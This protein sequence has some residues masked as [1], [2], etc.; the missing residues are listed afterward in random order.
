MKKDFPVDAGLQAAMQW[1]EKIVALYLDEESVTDSEIDLSASSNELNQGDR[2]FAFD[3]DANT[4]VGIATGMAVYGLHPVVHIAEE[5]LF[6]SALQQLGNA[7]AQYR[8]RSGGQYSAPMT[9]VVEYS[10]GIKT[11][12]FMGSMPGM[13]VFAPSSQQDFTNILDHLTRIPDPTLV[14][15]P[16]DWPEID[17]LQ[18][19][20]MESSVDYRKARIL[21]EGTELTL[22]SFGT[23]TQ[24]AYAQLDE[25]ANSGRSIELVDLRSLN[26]L[27]VDTIVTSVKKTGRLVILQESARS[28]GTAAELAAQISE[29]AIDSLLAPVR[30]IAGFDLPDPGALREVIRPDMAMLEQAIT[31]VAQFR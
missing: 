13:Q 30:R 2:V 21:R 14:Y 3:C 26:P 23:L 7:T 28:Y 8:Y 29:Y 31:E 20:A 5:D 12:M 11:D 17:D 18:R 25:W 19:A 6:S 22:V 1:N 10:G 16:K 24:F 27:D 4:L 9:V 15:A